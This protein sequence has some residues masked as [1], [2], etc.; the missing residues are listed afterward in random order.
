M[1]SHRDTLR[2]E[3]GEGSGLLLVLIPPWKTAKE[4]TV[5]LRKNWYVGGRH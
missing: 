3:M 4:N 5:L 2:V 1:T